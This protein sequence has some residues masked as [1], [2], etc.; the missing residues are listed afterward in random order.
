MFDLNKL[1]VEAYEEEKSRILVLIG[2][3]RWSRL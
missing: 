2:L 1:I 3:S